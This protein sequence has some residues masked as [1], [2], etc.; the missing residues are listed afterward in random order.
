MAN[1]GSGSYLRLEAHHFVCIGVTIIRLE[2][3]YTFKPL[4]AHEGSQLRDFLYLAVHIPPGCPPPDRAIIDE[5]LMICYTQNW[6]EPND[7]GVVAQTKQSNQLVGIAWIRQMTHSCPGYGFIDGMTPSLA[8]SVLP[9]FRGQGIGTE[10]LTEL[11]SQAPSDQ[12]GLSVQNSN[13]AKRLYERMGFS[14]MRESAEESVMVWTRL[15]A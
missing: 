1:S 15:S 11:L 9:S 5:P 6:G 12:I 7:F 2:H 8:I 4:E 3:T 13:P 14:T 10:L